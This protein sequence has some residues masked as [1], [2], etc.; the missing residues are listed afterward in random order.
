MGG[1]IAAVKSAAASMHA[2]LTAALTNLRIGVGAYKDVGDVYVFKNFQSVA[3]LTAAQFS[4]ALTGW[5]ASGGGDTP[6]AQLY[7]MQQVATQ[8]AINWRSSSIKV[9]VWFGDA[10]G[11][12]PSLGVSLAL[13][14]ANLLAAS[15]KT[16]ALDCSLLNQG[17]QANS[18][19]SATGG[20]YYPSI[21]A[22]NIAATMVS[23]LGNV[24]VTIKPVVTCPA[25]TPI[26]IKFD[27][28]TI[29]ATALKPGCFNVSVKACNDLQCARRATYTCTVNMVDTSNNQVIASYPITAVVPGTDTTPPVFT[30]GIMPMSLLVECPYKYPFPKVKAIDDCDDNPSVKQVTSSAQS[31]SCPAEFTT[32]STWTATDDSG[33]SVSVSQSVTYQ[34]TTPPFIKPSC[35]NLTLCLNE[36]SDFGSVCISMRRYSECF[37]D[38]CSTIKPPTFGCGNC[39]TP[40]NSPFTFSCTEQSSDVLCFSIK[41][42][43]REQPFCCNLKASVTDACGNTATYAF[44]KVCVYSRLTGP[45]SPNTCGGGI[46]TLSPTATGGGK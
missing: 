23:S 29:N 16:I 42:M 31:S 9:V 39:S 6:E 45:P 17:G 11:H 24:A 18:L 5:V 14:K 33:N 15:I 26:V 38:A 12:D 4:T 2:S 43:P 1:H 10:P 21:S 41:G 36:T 20:Q 46:Y 30:P 19:A 22:A 13:A 28:P 32:T 25:N 8:P 34:D 37:G 44:P 35:N 3:S 27:P 7:A 40:A